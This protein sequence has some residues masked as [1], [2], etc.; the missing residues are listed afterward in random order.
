M[1]PTMFSKFKK[2]L[3]YNIIKKQKKTRRD[4]HET[5]RRRSEGGG[6]G[7]RRN[8]RQAKAGGRGGEVRDADAPLHILTFRSLCTMSCW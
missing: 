4:R 1:R 5:R 6:K 2:S 8:R 3:K 7:Q